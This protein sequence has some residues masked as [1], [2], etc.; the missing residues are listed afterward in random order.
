MYKKKEISKKKSKF[1]GIKNSP[2][3]KIQYYMNKKSV[4]NPFGA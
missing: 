1:I 4:E 3:M 2:S